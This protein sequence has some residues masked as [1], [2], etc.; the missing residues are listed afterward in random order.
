VTTDNIYL[1]GVCMIVITKK[2]KQKVLKFRRQTVGFISAIRGFQ[3]G[4]GVEVRS[5]KG[6]YGRFFKV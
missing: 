3:R 1:I 5:L 6:E 2:R 4:T